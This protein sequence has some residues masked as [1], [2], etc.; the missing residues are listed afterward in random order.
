MTQSRRR[1]L[2]QVGVVS[3]VPFLGFKLKTAAPAASI[4]F[5][6]SAI[7][8]G[9]NIEGAIREISSLGFT[10]IQ[11]RGNAVTKW[12][13]KPEE[14]KKLVNDAKLDVVMLSSG[15]ADINTGNDEAEIAK[16]VVNAKFIKAVGGNRMQVTNSSRPKTGTVS[17]EDLVKYAKMLTE[18]GKRTADVGVETT[19]HNHM[20]Q[21]GQTPQEVDTILQNTDPK[22][23]GFLLDIAHY[24]QG[25]GD[26]ATAIHTYK[27]RIKTLHIKDVKNT[28]APN[29]YQFVE[30][31]QG[32]LDF[33][34]VFDAL[35]KINYRG[36][37]VVELDAIPVKGRT[38]LE[39]G[40]IAKQYLT[41]TMKFKM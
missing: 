21:L 13:Q 3:A 31:G 22:R 20:G 17:T 7:T 33:P 6:Y 15:N 14:L 19:Y 10:G 36:Y 39:S 25:G 11:L 28:D 5:G 8:W 40:Q 34:A 1:F 18:I 35:N 41:S 27:D 16:H 24:L 38:T 32:R 2:T 4:K 37:A 12:G 29:G 30:L 9:D 23:V 26:P